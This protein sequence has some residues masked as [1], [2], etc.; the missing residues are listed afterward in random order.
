MNK[1]NYAFDS[2]MT[3][4]SLSG[5]VGGFKS[6]IPANAVRPKPIVIPKSK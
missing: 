4:R 6:S 1:P 5:K 2:K 3:E